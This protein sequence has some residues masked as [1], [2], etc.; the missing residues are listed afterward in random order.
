MRYLV[1]VLLLTAPLFA[2]DAASTCLIVKHASTAHQ[3]FV[4]GA[5]WQYVEGDFPRSMKWKSNIRDRDIRKIKEIGGKVVIVNADYS[6]TDLEDARKQCASMAEE[7][8]SE[9]KR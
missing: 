6:A 3:F 9:K 1:G 5:N 8:T 2:A 4:S 7:N